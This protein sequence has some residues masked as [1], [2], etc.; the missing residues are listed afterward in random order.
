MKKNAL[1]FWLKNR[2][3]AMILAWVL[4]LALMC[5]VDNPYFNGCLIAVLFLATLFG[6]T[7]LIEEHK[8]NSSERLMWRKYLSI[9]EE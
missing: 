9:F 1:K 3:T 2:F 4:G 8:M 6:G 7:Y 5:G